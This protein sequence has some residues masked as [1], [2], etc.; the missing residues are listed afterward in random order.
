MA[1]KN[2]G[3]HYKHGYFGTRTYKSWSEMKYRCGNPNR[4]DYINIS[5]CERWAKFENF[6]NNMG[7]RPNNTTLD[8]INNKGNYEPSN[9]RWADNHTQATNKSNS[10]YFEF[11]GKSFTLSDWSKICGIKRSTLAMRIYCKHWTTEEAITIKKGGH[12]FG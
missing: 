3:N 2:R 12:R 5:Y 9:C 7:E 6:L 1:E 11:Q 10:R 8:R 4:A